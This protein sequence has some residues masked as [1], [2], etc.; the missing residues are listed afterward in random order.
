[1]GYGGMARYVQLGCAAFQVEFY[2]KLFIYN[3]TKLQINK[4]LVRIENDF[5]IHIYLM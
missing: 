1:M 2:L 5:N 4:N 3:F